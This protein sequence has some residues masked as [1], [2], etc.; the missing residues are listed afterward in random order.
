MLDPQA[1]A[2]I[3]QSCSDAAIGYLTAAN[4]A[5]AAMAEQALRHWTQTFAAMGI[6]TEKPKPR[7]SW[8]VEPERDEPEV[9]AP[10]GAAAC[11]MPWMAAASYGGSTGRGPAG[12]WDLFG[13]WAELMNPKNATAWP[14][15]WGMMAAGVPQSV[16]WPTARA[17]AAAMDA[18]NTAARSFEEAVVSYRS[19]GGHAVARVVSKKRAY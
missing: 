18:F 8:Y 3:T 4:A 6:E 12:P 9:S 19:S 14:M 16:A 11:M 2:R 17:N 13:A 1:Q 10:R 7:K 5:Y 15:A